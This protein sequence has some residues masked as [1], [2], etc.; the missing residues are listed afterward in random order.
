[1]KVVGHTDSTASPSYNLDLSH[2]RAQ[3]VATALKPL[4][5]VAGATFSIDG[6]GETQPVASN[7]TAEGRAENRRV[8]I[9]FTPKSR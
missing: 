7:A 8:S 9:V 1:M 5:T 4:V 6:K 2:R 3:A